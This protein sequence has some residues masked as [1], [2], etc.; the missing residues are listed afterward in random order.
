MKNRLA[1][2]VGALVLATSALGV[3][4][5][6]PATVAAASYSFCGPGPNYYFL[7]Q[8]KLSSQVNDYFDGAQG[9]AY[10]RDLHSCDTFGFT[11][12]GGTFVLFANIEQSGTS[13]IVQLAYGE[14]GD[15][16]PHFYWTG[17]DHCGGVA[18]VVSWAES[19]QANHLYKASISYIVSTHNWRYSLQDLTDNQTWLKD[20]YASWRDGTTVWWGTETYDVDSAMGPD[21]GTAAIKLYAMRYHLENGNLWMYRTGF[22]DCIRQVPSGTSYWHCHVA[23]SLYT[24]DTLNIDTA[25]DAH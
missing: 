8:K 5:A 12:N 18:S 17:C 10:I 19:P 24:N 21:H 22:T 13:N 20:V 16:V 9:T 11:E 7:T 6:A 15:D 25:T 23:T 1:A 4:L 3:S 2:L 14:G